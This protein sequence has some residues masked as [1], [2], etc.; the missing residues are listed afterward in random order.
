MSATI[1]RLLKLNAGMK[2]CIQRTAN[3]NRMTWMTD[4][5]IIKQQIHNLSF[6]GIPLI[7]LQYA[8]KDYYHQ[9]VLQL[10]EPQED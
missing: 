2:I 9:A 1:S 10:P 3:V 8:E 5:F 4:L 7:Q 6:Q